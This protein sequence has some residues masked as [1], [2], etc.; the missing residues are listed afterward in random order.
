[1]KLPYPFSF[2]SVRVLPLMGRRGTV[3]PC[4]LRFR[5]SCFLSTQDRVS[6]SGMMQR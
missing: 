1:M 3:I 5:F 4:V 6:Q 2:L